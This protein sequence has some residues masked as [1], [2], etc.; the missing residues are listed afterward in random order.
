MGVA[1][2]T[3]K[4][5]IVMILQLHVT[6]VK[7]V[8]LVGNFVVRK[9]LRGPGLQEALYLHGRGEGKGK[10]RQGGRK[11]K[12]RKREEKEKRGKREGGKEKKRE[13][14]KRKDREGG[15]GGSCLNHSRLVGHYIAA[16][17]GVGLVSVTYH[18]T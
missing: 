1:W 4:N 11:E 3:K 18:A 8:L 7:V 9:H 17:Q 10:R 6:N 14:R 13:G 5:M 16:Y 15:E 12:R 2:L